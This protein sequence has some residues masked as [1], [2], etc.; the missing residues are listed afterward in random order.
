MAMRF[1]QYKPRICCTS[2]IVYMYVLVVCVWTYLWRALSILWNTSRTSRCI[3]QFL[4]SLHDFSNLTNIFLTSLRLHKAS[5]RVSLQIQYL[6]N[7]VSGNSKLKKSTCSFIF[8][9]FDTWSMIWVSCHE[10]QQSVLTSD[11]NLFSRA[12]IPSSVVSASK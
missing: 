5:S 3:R 1:L 6:Q 10:Q 11:A 2:C 9:H 7:N 4:S 12:M 8:L